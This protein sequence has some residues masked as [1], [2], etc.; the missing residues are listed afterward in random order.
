MQTRG[1]LDMYKVQRNWNDHCKRR[2]SRR[3]VKM[4]ILRGFIECTI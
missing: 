2:N 4:H 1:Y 3:V